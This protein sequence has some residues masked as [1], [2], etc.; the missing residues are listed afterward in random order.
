MALYKLD[1]HGEAVHTDEE[2]L[3]EWLTS[4]AGQDVFTIARHDIIE[5]A[6]VV[7]AIDVLKCPRHNYRVLKTVL[8]WF[9]PNVRYNDQ[10]V[11]PFE[12][13]IVGER[14][15]IS[16]NMRESAISAHKSLVNTTLRE[17]GGR[18]LIR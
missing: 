13:G 2:G 7:I 3:K 5:S 11:G 16:T 8:T 6:G 18:V 12:I 17:F 10:Y 15:D 4:V 14:P 1:E 9:R